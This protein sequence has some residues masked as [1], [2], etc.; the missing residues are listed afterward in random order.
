MIGPDGFSDL[1]EELHVE[2]RHRAA[3]GNVEPGDLDVHLELL[4]LRFDEQLV[5]LFHFVFDLTGE[6][7]VLITEQLLDQL[8]DGLV[9]GKRFHSGVV[10]DGRGTTP[11][12]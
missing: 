3:A 12:R 5:Q 8:V 7:K 11:L 9:G 10:G 1:L 2:I 6:E 4:A